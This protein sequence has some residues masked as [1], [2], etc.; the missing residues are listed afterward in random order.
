MDTL[1]SFT[2]A[3]EDEGVEEAFEKIC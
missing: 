1:L 2:S 3:K